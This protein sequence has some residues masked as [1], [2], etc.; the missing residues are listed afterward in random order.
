MRPL[1]DTTPATKHTSETAKVSAAVSS[2]HQ[3]TKT[4]RDEQG[5]L[6]I[7]DIG[8][9]QC[10]SSLSMV[11]DYTPLPSPTVPVCWSC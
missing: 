1:G 3:D 10:V 11:I 2:Y 8:N 4:Q 5:L 9:L 6:N 7:T